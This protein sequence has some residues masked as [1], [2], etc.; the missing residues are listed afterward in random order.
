MTRA[1]SSV[2]FLFSISTPRLTL[3]VPLT[4]SYTL[5]IAYFGAKAPNHDYKGLGIWN[6]S[7]R[8]E[9]IRNILMYEWNCSDSR[10]RYDDPHW[11]LNKA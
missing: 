10:E 4:Y 9:R 5:E 2:T 6:A 1:P 7:W 8:Y 3:K 11:A